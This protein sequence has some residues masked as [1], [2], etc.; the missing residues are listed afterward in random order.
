MSEEIKNK[1]KERGKY[2][3]KIT[4]SILFHFIIL[5]VILLIA[6][7]TSYWQGWLFV[8]YLII[9]FVIQLIL[10]TNNTS[11]LKER[12]KPGPGV[13]KW[14]KL[15][16]SIYIPT[17]CILIITATLDTGRFQW[18]TGQFTYYL[19]IIG[20]FLLIASSVIVTRA[21]MVNKFYSRLVRIQS[22]RNHH[23][24]KDG[25]YRYIRHPGNFSGIIL[26]TGSS[27]ALGSIYGLIPAFFIICMLIIRTYLEDKTLKKELTGYQEYSNYVKYRLIPGIW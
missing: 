2:I 17:Y 12:E 27:L 23:V 1:E 19:Y 18:T 9:V 6:G 25:P 20:Y 11:L 22:D 26:T 24:I 7:N 15:L 4:V 14:D 3:K 8:I 5:I 10:F 13:K 16:Q 21:M